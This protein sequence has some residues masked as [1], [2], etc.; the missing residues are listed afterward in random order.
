[1]IQG[2]NRRGS[3][4]YLYL[5][6]YDR[7]KSSGQVAA[8][9]VSGSSNIKADSTI[10]DTI[11][12]HCLAADTAYF[13]I[14]SSGA[15]EYRFKYEMVNTSPNDAEPNNTFATA[16]A[17]RLDS[18]HNG[19]IGYMNNGVA[20]ANDYSYIALPSRGAVQIITEGTNTSGSGGYLYLYGYKNRSGQQVLSK[21]ISN[22]SN[23]AAGATIRDTIRIDCLSTDTL[24][25]R[26][27]SSGCFRYSFTVK[28]IDL[29]PVAEI[30]H[31]VAGSLH[32]F[33]NLSSNATSYVWKLGDSTFSTNN[34]PPLKSFSA[35]SYQVKLIAKNTVCNYTDTASLQL[36]VKGIDRF[37]P[38]S[39]GPGNIEFTAY[40]GGF[41]EGMQ[42]T[43]KKGNVVLK[44]SVSWVNEYGNIF[45]ALIN[46]HNAPQG[47]YDIEVKTKDTTY[48]FPAGFTSEALVD[49]LRS[50]IIGRD[51]IRINTKTPYSVRI[52]N[53]GNTMAGVVEVFVLFPSYM[54]VTVLDSVINLLEPEPDDINFDTLP[55]FTKV[56]RERGYPVDGNM[57]SFYVAGVP[58]HGFRDLSF[59]V[60]S[61]V[62]KQSIYSWV[63]GPMSGSDYRSWADDC[64]KSKIKLATDLINDGIA[65]VPVADCAWGAAK[66]AASALYS[67]YS[68]ATGD[69]SVSST[70]AGSVKTVAGLM[71]DCAGELGALAGGAPGVAIETADVLTDIS[72]LS[73][74]A[75]VNYNQIDIDCPDD[76]EEPKQK[77]VDVRTSLDP[78][79]KSGP[80]G[81]GAPNYILGSKKLMNYT[82]Y[83]ENMRTATLPAQEVKIIDTLDKSRFDLSSFRALSF[84]IGTKKYPLPAGA[85]D[86]SEDIPFNNQLNVRLSVNLDTATG[87]MTT[88]FKT[89][90]ILTG[91][92]TTDPLLGFLPPNITAPEGEGSLSYAIDLKDGLM[93]GTVIRNKASII[94][95]NN[96][97]IITDEWMNTLDKNI[98][99]SKVSLAYQLNDSAVVVKASGND[100]SSGLKYYRLYVSEDGGDYKYVGN[101]SDTTVYPGK[102]N[103]T[104]SFYVVAVDSVGNLETKSPAA[105]ATVT[106][107]PLAIVLGNITATNVGER[108]R[109]N[110]NTLTEDL[111][112]HFEIEKSTDGRTFK[113]MTIQYAKGMA[114]AYTVYDDQPAEGRNHYRLKTYDR[115]G[116]F[117]TS[118]V[119]SVFVLKN[120]VFAIEAFPN[121]AQN[122]L[123]I[124]IYGD[125]DGRGKITLVNMMGSIVLQS[126]VTT[127]NVVLDLSKQTPGTYFI[128]YTDDNK[129]Q[130]IKITKQ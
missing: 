85:F 121:P 77:P 106:Q 113:L 125:I 34:A 69:G 105:E 129:S 20:D 17:L 115:S 21:Y 28:H 41:H 6:V 65:I 107:Q 99:V 38:K 39:G 61:T 48:Y 59:M 24:F 23:V 57:Y 42:V 8:K 116:G 1:M 103:H 87:I 70:N 7:R 50:E 14:T 12:V 93:D 43:F 86:F 29:D 109:I 66:A 91:E 27:T 96:Q 58:A 102:L 117:K 90:D 122:R 98:P 45:A 108:N 22:S 112:D 88:Y 51:I 71:K 26:W 64:N 19:H 35:G 5:N 46:M 16:S 52:H 60:N 32:E 84:S 13:K 55:I 2:T 74:N 83:F 114:S 40:G 124:N 37:T 97:P 110:W 4:G 15:F 120:K 63:K 80:S 67:L 79:A 89:L 104:Y 95:D 75:Y 9:Y 118:K 56:T 128:K 25:L 31:N 10:Y 11:L 92:V 111:G 44:D 73:S 100:P 119:V 72:V 33:S 36:T 127:N 126:N 81:Y 101:I 30:A 3:G 49:K 68:W 54:S 94:F 47:V 78:N 62:G 18:T 76:P 82:I 53:E 130:V 123:T